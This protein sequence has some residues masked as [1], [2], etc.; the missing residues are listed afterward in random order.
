MYA[1]L[2]GSTGRLQSHGSATS[3]AI[4][5]AAV[6]IAEDGQAKLDIDVHHPGSTSA[7]VFAIFTI[8][9]MEIYDDLWGFIG[10]YRDL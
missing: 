7:I 8:L 10:I 3:V 1:I 5:L 9:I 2:S 6:A 4:C